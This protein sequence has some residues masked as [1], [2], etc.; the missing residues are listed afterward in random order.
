MIRRQKLI[1]IVASVLLAAVGTGLLVAYVRSAE[2]RA[3]KGEKTVGAAQDKSLPALDELMSTAEIIA[4]SE[5]RTGGDDSGTAATA[6]EASLLQLSSP[7]GIAAATPA[8]PTTC[9]R[10]SATWWR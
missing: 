7:A 8:S 9:R 5:T 1:G 6:Y 10:C 4:G 2:N 3:L